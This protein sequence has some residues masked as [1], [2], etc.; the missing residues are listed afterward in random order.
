MEKT[1]K[2]ELTRTVHKQN[3]KM[4][5]KS[6]V[7]EKTVPK[8]WIVC[9]NF[10]EPI[11]VKNTSIV[12]MKTP[13]GQIFNEYLYS[14]HQFT[15][16]MVA[17]EMKKLGYRLKTLFSFRNTSFGYD[18]DDLNVTVGQETYEINRVWIQI[19]KNAPDDSKFQE[20]LGHFKQLKLETN[21]IVGIHCTH[22]FNRTGFII[23]RY[24]VDVMQMSLIDA[25]T[26]FKQKR[27]PG[28]Y[29]PDYINEL[30]RFYKIEPSWDTPI[31]TKDSWYFPSPESLPHYV[32]K[33]YI[34]MDTEDAPIVGKVINSVLNSVLK[35]EVLKMCDINPTEGRLDFPG[36]QPVTLARSNE[37]RL[38]LN[39]TYRATY[40]SDGTR[41]LMLCYKGK[42]Y[43]VDRKFEFREVNIVM[44]N[45]KGE[46]L[47]K[48]LLDGELVSEK[49]SE[50]DYNKHHYEVPIPDNPMNFLIFD[51]IQFEEL[52]LIYNDWDTRMDYVEKGCIAFRKMWME[53][54]PEMFQNEDFRVSLKKQWPLNKLGK[55]ENYTFHCVLHPTDGII[56]T[57]LSMK[58]IMGQCLEILK[59]K[60]IELNS[61]DFI[62]LVNDNICYLA[63][64][65]SYPRERNDNN[66]KR[67]ADIPISI[68]DAVDED[69]LKDIDHKIVECSFDV[70]SRA[71]YP[72][73]FRTDKTYPNAYSTFVKVF[74]SIEDDITVPELQRK[75]GNDESPG[76]D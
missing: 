54:K 17:L 65:I 76:Y 30:F 52:N 39:K 44:V 6:N 57:P 73:R 51:I 47:D 18:R 36:S 15:P 62:A 48:T 55:L 8:A 58:Y 45:R 26:L 2:P 59:W 12:P 64:R 43:I 41:Y 5:Y 11:K 14:K 33:E 23:V 9:P 72:L 34:K 22:G 69:I 32:Q 56:F 49:I 35:Y 7:S 61:S 63:V 24:L 1:S 27:P 74:A 38:V 16:K 13:L 28:I 29:K 71:W 20:F 37:E 70:N 21:D 31:G 4:S 60:P 75:F 19:G 40:K 53:K 3:K 25:L 42:T 10:G 46:R 67:N 66:K 50:E 68:L